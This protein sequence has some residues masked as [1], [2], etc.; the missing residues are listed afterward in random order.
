MKIKIAKYEEY[1]TDEDL[2]KL[3]KRLWKEYPRIIIDKTRNVV[4]CFKE[5]PETSCDLITAV[6]TIGLFCSELQDKL[7]KL[8]RELYEFA[9][10]LLGT[11]SGW[12]Y[13]S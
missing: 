11:L 12:N 3:V 13:D 9:S 10:N 6:Q 5:L 4:Y 2:K 8:Y 1:E 7:D